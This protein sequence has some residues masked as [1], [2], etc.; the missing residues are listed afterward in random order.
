LTL[1]T[2]RLLLAQLRK[3][4]QR[5]ITKTSSRK[6]ESKISRVY[7]IIKNNLNKK[8]AFK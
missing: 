2:G 6:E 1:P 4:P 3:Q 7:E 5:N 8:Y